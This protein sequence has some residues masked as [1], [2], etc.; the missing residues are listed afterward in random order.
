ML[1]GA[2]F[3][4]E[5][6]KTKRGFV[7]SVIVGRVFFE[8][9]TEPSTVSDTPAPQEVGKEKAG[10]VTAKHPGRDMQAGSGSLMQQG[11]PASQG[12]WDSYI[13]LCST[14]LST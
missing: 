1:R 14:L 6:N 9:L 3:S 11:D 2:R 7:H 4:L 10:P 12:G 13:R 8:R 5:R